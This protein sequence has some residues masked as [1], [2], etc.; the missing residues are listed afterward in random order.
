VRDEYDVVVAG[1]GLAGL[2]AGLTAA[3]L[4]RSVAVLS[5]VV[6]GGLLLTIDRI[7]GLPGYPDGLAGYE[8][9]PTVQTQ[10]EAAGAEVAAAELGAV[11]AADGGWA[12][13]TDHGRIHGRALVLATGARFREL[14]VPGEDRLRGRG[15]ST[16]ASCDGPLLGGKTAAVVGGGDSAL[17]EALALAECGGPVLILHRG[18]ELDGQASYRLRAA[19]HPAIEIRLGVVVEEILGDDAVA[20]VRVRDVAGGSVEE[21]AVGG[22]FPFVGLV[23]NTEPF[24]ET[25]SLDPGGAVLVDGALRTSAPGILAAGVVRSGAPGRAAAAIGDGALAAV[26]A[27]ACLAAGVA[28]GA[29]APAGV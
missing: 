26:S 17:Q 13:A 5:G 23:P 7:D 4:G 1:G 9:C 22:V 19:E 16:C 10:A 28:P 6:P 11:E 2:T 12:V 20:A 15:V 18:E 25:V 14:G 8:L 24:T 21:L 27:D 29:A 3:R